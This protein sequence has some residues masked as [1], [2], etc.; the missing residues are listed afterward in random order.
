[1]VTEDPTLGLARRKGRLALPRRAVFG[2]PLLAAVASGVLALLAD[3]PRP[4]P[5]LLAVAPVPAL[6]A[7]FAM[8][9][10]ATAIGAVVGVI[11]TLA[12]W[13]AL[14]DPAFGTPLFLRAAFAAAYGASGAGV[15]AT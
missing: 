5:L 13:R 2:G 11:A 4:H 12:L 14:G 1:M 8:P 6:V 3:Y 9:A 7:A 10:A 15:Y